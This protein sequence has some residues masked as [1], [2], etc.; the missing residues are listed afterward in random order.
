LLCASLLLLG[1]DVKSNTSPKKSDLAVVISGDTAG[2]LTPCGCTSNQSGGLLRRATYLKSQRAG[3][4]VIYLDAGG[5]P[6][7][8]SEYHKVRFEAIL[9]GEALMNVAAHNVGGREAALGAA[10]LR[11]AASRLHVPLVS[12]NARDRSGNLIFEPLKIVSAGG[13]R[14]AVVGVLDPK[15]AAGDIAIDDPRRAI[16][17]ALANVKGEYDSAI[18][19]A[20]L[21]EQSL[22]Q[23]ATEL[24]EAD[25]VIGGPTGQAISPHRAG[26]VLLG[27]ATN[28]GKFLV[29][30]EHGGSGWS[31]QV[32]EMNGDYAD[33]PQQQANVKTYLARLAERDFAA[34]ETGLAAPLPPNVPADYRIAGSQSCRDC[35]KADDKLWH[36]SKHSHAIEVLNERGM[37]VDP[38]CLSCHTTGYGLTGGFISLKRSADL[39]GVGCENC[40]GPSAA[41]VSDPKIKTPFAASDQCARCH[42]HENSP[43]FVYSRYWKKIE[44]GKEKATIPAKASA[45]VQP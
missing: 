41:H 31:G 7:G 44:H 38:F 24:P 10:Y 16:S 1:C 27:A 40:H 4:D 8:T 6:G 22:E 39:V 23:L 20:Y 37:Q 14:V 5:A 29:R 42:D 18:V 36:D 32:V 33:D 28:K 12:A 35:H 25:A 3:G 43:K 9:A 19:L 11:E 45:E 17:T 30:L 34:A 15:Y 26:P 21:S 13:M 2:W